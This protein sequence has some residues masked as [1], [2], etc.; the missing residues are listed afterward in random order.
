MLGSL[1]FSA[2][3][4]SVRVG[5]GNLVAVF[6]EWG[7]W[8]IPRRGMLF[9]DP[10]TGELGAGDDAAVLDVLSAWLDTLA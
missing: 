5:F 9:A 3:A 10:D 7:T 8:K 6:H 4:D 1:N 2:D